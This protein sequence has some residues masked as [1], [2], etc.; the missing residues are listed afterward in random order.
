MKK[1]NLVF[2]FITFIIIGLIIFFMPD[3][4]NKFQELDTPKVEKVYDNNKTED[5]IEPINMDSDIINNLTYPVMRNDQSKIDSYYQLDVFTVNNLNNNDILYNAFLD[6]YDGYLVD[7]GSMGCAS[8]SKEFDATYLE[9]R[10]K[11]IIGKSVKYNLEDFTVPKNSKYAGLWKYN[12]NS[13]S[14]IYYGDCSKVDNSTIYYDLKKL[15]NVESSKDNHTIYLYYYI[16]VAKIDNN[17]YTIYSDM[18]MVNEVAHGN[19]SDISEIDNIFN[20]LDMNNFKTYKYIFK[21][22]L[23]SYDNYCFYK[24]EWIND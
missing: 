15:Y 20:D 8:N 24:G 3:I 19:I 7:Y 5:K 13:N 21:L 18:N 10:I 12:S 16:G 11:N 4:Y 17:N 2:L 6:I 23:C 22:G 14:Y 9:S 1:G